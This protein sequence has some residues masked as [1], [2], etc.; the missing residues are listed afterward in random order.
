ML[1]A[2]L[3]PSPGWWGHRNRKH[4]LDGGRRRCGNRSVSV[5]GR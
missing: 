4:R 1:S 3:T 2:L 5:G